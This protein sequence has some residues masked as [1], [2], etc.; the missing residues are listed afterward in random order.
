MKMMKYMILHGNIGN[1]EGTPCIIP[2][3]T[4]YYIQNAK[5]MRGSY[6]L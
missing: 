3:E 6:D 1:S 4:V 5:N 2:G